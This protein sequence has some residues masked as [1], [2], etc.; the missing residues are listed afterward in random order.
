[1]QMAYTRVF[2]TLPLIIL[3]VLFLFFSFTS[4]VAS[5]P[6]S[7][8]WD[9]SM[10]YFD[11]FFGC[12]A[13]CSEIKVKVCN[14]RGVEPMQGTSEYQLFYNQDGDPQS[15][16][17]LYSGTVAQLDPDECQTITFKPENRGGSY[18]F[19]AKQRPGFPGEPFVK[20]D[21]CKVN[22]CADPAPSPT[23]ITSS[24][25]TPQP[26][27]SPIPTP[28]PVVTPN[29]SPSPNPSPKPIP[30]PTSEPTNDLD[31]PNGSS[32]GDTGGGTGGATG[33]SSIT[34]SSTS[35]TSGT[36]GQVAGV[37]H[38]AATGKQETYATLGLL[39]GIGM[40]CKSCFD[41]YARMNK[42]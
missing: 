24:S 42:S 28:T 31:D 12:E 30:S 29:A 33:G 36:N 4:S 20:S 11:P 1:M 39:A 37:T 17:I 6:F 32:G 13:S 19:V 40:M 35:G 26:N 34:I 8:D 9:G 21:I 3:F 38:L 23:P 2:F 7:D 14:R 16:T 25:P 18:T 15:G 27:P 41:L 22:Q 10:I 5:T